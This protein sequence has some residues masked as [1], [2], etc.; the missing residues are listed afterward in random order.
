MQLSCI[1]SQ[2][3]NVVQQTSISYWHPEHNRIK[4]NLSNMTWW[5]ATVIPLG[6]GSLVTGHKN[7]INF[8]EIWLRDFAWPIVPNHGRTLFKIFETERIIINKH[9]SG[10]YSQIIRL[11][12]KYTTS[13]ESNGTFSQ[14]ADSDQLSRKKC[15]K[16][17]SHRHTLRLLPLIIPTWHASKLFRW[18]P[19]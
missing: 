6:F 17:R 4:K 15:D 13:R 3:L 10:Q 14:L 5:A 12:P 1:N 2:F 9:F 7:T 18:N 8:A 11:S 19:Y 16:W